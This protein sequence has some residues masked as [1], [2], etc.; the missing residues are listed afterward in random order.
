ML[1]QTYKVCVDALCPSQQ[2]FSNVS[3]SGMNQYLAEDNVSC[4]RTQHRAY[5]ESRTSD[6]R[7]QV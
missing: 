3:F 4:S 1:E 2:V 6:P 5:G 7:S